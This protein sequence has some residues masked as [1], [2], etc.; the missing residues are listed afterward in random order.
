MDKLICPNCNSEKVKTPGGF[1]NMLVD[2]V[3]VKM[4]LGFLHMFFEEK[5]MRNKC[6][7]CNHKW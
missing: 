7:E 1:A 5:M 6:R 4:Y 2:S 3:V